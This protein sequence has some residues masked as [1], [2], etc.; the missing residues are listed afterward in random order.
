MTADYHMKGQPGKVSTAWTKSMAGLQ[1]L[2]LA[3]SPGVAF[4]S[5]WI[6]HDRKLAASFT[7]RQNTV[8]VVSDGTAV[9]GEGPIGPDAFHPVGEGKAI[10]MKLFTGLDAVSCPIALEG[11]DRHLLGHDTPAE[12]ESY[13]R[14]F[15]K[16]VR[17]L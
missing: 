13:V 17:A 1:D 15:I 3:Y 16:F 12:M 11:L 7:N 14:E 6:H 8:Y 2:K 9:L 4:A 10:L 5:R